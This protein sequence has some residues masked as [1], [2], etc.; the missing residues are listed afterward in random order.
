MQTTRREPFVLPPDREAHLWRVA[1]LLGI[2]A[3]LGVLSLTGQI[4]RGGR[5]RAG[6]EDGVGAACELK[7]H[8]DRGEPVQLHQRPGVGGT[9]NEFSA[10]PV[11]ALSDDEFELAEI[12]H[13]AL[14]AGELAGPG[15]GGTKNDSAG[16]GRAA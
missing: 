1:E 6:M 15:V 9:K 11:G 12:R 5:N 16:G 14:L 2:D 4:I 8:M 10:V 3:N 7:F 13:E